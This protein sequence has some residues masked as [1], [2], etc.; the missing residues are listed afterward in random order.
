[1]KSLIYYKFIARAIL[2]K[3]GVPITKE[4]IEAEAIRLQEQDVNK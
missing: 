4:N 1:M 3:N 2:F